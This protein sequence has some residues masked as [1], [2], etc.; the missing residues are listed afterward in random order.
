MQKQLNKPKILVAAPTS[1]IKDYCFSEWIANVRAFSY[2]NFDVFLADNSRDKEY[3]KALQR[4]GLKVKHI[5]QTGGRAIQ[6]YVALSHEACR[7][8]AISGGYDYMLHLETD[9]FPPHN[10]IELLLAHRKKVCGAMYHIKQGEESTLMLQQ[11]ENHEELFGHAYSY[12]LEE[13]DMSFVDGKLKSVFSLGLGCV[14]I[15]R[16]VLKK[17][18]FRWEEGA[19]VFP[20]SIWSG[21]LDMSNQPKYVDTSILCEHKNTSTLII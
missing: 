10:I 20:D 6:H 4:C 14:L 11:L 17:F 9:V 21:E 12:S 2:S 19:D 13:E 3:H 5:P 1:S 7:K 16:S 15:H 8:Q 18:P